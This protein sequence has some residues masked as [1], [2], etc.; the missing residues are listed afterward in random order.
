MSTTVSKSYQVNPH[1]TLHTVQ[2]GSPNARTVIILLHFW[3][4]STRTFSQLT[5]LLSSSDIL[6]VAVDFPG[7]GS[8]TGPIDD[9]SAYS[10][11]SLA[12]SVESLIAQLNVR[13]FILVGHSMGGKVAQ[14]IAGRNLVHGLQ[15]LILLAPAPPSPLILPEEMRVQ[16]LAAYG[17]PQSAEFVARNVLSASPLSDQTI[18]IV[19]EDMLG[20]SKLATAAWPGYAMA[21]DVSEI[22]SATTARTLVLVGELDSVETPERA[23]NEVVGNIKGAKIVVLPG[24]GHLLP[25]EASKEVARYIDEF[26]SADS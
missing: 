13:N 16:Q 15:G 17:S 18:K 12:S 7:W 2:S 25:L 23:R 9:P 14:L 20:G 6:T 26:C 19:V 22:V 3:G 24:V 10:I 5:P 21:E 4:G 8:S 1:T 11:A